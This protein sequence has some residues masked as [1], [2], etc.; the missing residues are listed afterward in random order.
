[1]SSD[2]S[3]RFNLI[4]RRTWYGDKLTFW[5][6]ISTQRALPFGSADDVKK[7]TR[8]VRDLMSKNSGYIL[9]PSK[10]IQGDV[11]AEN[12]LALIETTEEV[13]SV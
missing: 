6:G 1:L 10:E 5:G 4:P 8:R 3:G 11:P 12:I 7:E 13:R 2:I 9:A